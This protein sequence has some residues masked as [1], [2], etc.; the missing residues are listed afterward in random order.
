MNAK[1]PKVDDEIFIK[2][3]FIIG[4]LHDNNYEKC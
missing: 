2:Y 4:G 1:A 3:A